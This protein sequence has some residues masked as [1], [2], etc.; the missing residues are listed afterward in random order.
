[1]SKSIWVQN[2]QTPPLH[3]V[4]AVPCSVCKSG[5]APLSEPCLGAGGGSQG[6]AHADYLGLGA[7]AAA[8]RRALS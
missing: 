4:D 7:A 8:H 3:G 2:N 6:G 1:M 5:C